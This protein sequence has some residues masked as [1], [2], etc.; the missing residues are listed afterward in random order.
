MSMCVS[1]YSHLR[2]CVCVC[3]Y[4]YICVCVQGDGTG[5]A[6]SRS[7]ATDRSV[8]CASS[9]ECVSE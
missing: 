6:L 1:E 4:V 2:T 9:G 5:C 7:N 8:H 3:V